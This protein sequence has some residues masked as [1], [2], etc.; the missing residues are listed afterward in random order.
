MQNMVISNS[1]FVEINMP[2]VSAGQKYYFSQ[3]QQLSE[4][5]IHAIEAFT[6]A[7]LS[8][9]PGL[10]TMFADANVKD[11]VLVLTVGSDEVIYQI[12]LYTLVAAK[13]AGL[14]R[15]FAH[16]KVNLTKSYIQLVN[17]ANITAGQSAAFTLYYRTQKPVH[18]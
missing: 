17:G 12:P 5:Y 9:T 2:A 4:V 13:N 7:S 8:K 15:Q 3:D 18:K 6:D 1:K 10:Y 14:I 11:I 16:L